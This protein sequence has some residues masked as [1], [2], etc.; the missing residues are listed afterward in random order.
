MKSLFERTKELLCVVTRAVYYFRVQNYYKAYNAARAIVRLLQ[1]YMPELTEQEAQEFLSVL[2][3][4]LEAMEEQDGTKLADIYEEGLLTLL[5]QKQQK[6]FETS[7]DTLKDYWGKNRRILRARFPEIYRKVLECRDNIPDSYQLSWAK[8]GDLVVEVAAD[9]GTVRINSMCNPQD[10]AILFAENIPDRSE[11][12]VIGFGMGY[13][14][15]FLMERQSCRHII[16]LENDLNQLAIALSYR[17]L[18]VVLENN[19]I[20]LVYCPVVEDYTKYLSQVKEDAKVC[21]WYPSVKAIA[22]SS[23]REMLENYQIELSSIDNMGGI[24]NNNF[25]ANIQKK[26]K[27]VSCLKENFK[28]K[29]VILAA[30]GPSLDDNMELLKQRD[31]S[32]SV[33]V[34][35]GKVARKLISAGIRPD[36]IVMTDGLPGTKVRI[37]GIEECGVPLIYLST[38]AARVVDAYRGERYIAFQEGFTDAEKQAKASGYPLFQ[39]GGSVATFAL[40][41]LIQFGCQQIICV[42]LDMG[43]PGVGNKVFDKKNLRKVEG[44]QEEYIYTSK[45]LDIYRRWIENRIKGVKAT[46]LINV[47]NGARIHGMK[48]KA[49]RQFI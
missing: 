44:V 24:L 2:A 4:A 8:T 13:H 32:A 37:Q 35:V 6:L 15:P 21:F 38:V 12:L 31:T 48:E 36:Y 47:S 11:Y 46:E 39:T 40:D 42:G 22:D 41:L 49:L 20:E 17:D 14:I 27:E 7:D 19:K 9:Y 16:I 3:M 25:K 28:G 45:T 33:L 5:Y 10:E 34:C 26:D 1:E 29:K 23:L 18:S 30:A 43:Y